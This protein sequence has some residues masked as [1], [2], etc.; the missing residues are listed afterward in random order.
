MEICTGGE[1]ILNRQSE[2]D[3]M[4]HLKAVSFLGQPLINLFNCYPLV[5]TRLYET[6]RQLE[7]HKLI[8]TN[9]PAKISDLRPYIEKA[10]IIEPAKALSACSYITNNSDIFRGME[11]NFKSKVYGTTVR[12]TLRGH[13]ALFLMGKEGAN[14]DTRS[15]DPPSQDKPAP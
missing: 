12:L 11:N 1:M 14:L 4:K 15:V 2:I 10:G 13:L 8:K 7:N 3:I 6:L 9:G 5:P